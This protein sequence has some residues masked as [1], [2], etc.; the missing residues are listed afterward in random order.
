[1]IGPS[2]A[3]KTFMDSKTIETRAVL[4]VTRGVQRGLGRQFLCSTVEPVL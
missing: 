3:K 2:A 1:M 4:L